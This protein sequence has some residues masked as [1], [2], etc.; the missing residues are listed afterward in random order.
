M[1]PDRVI[2]S[3]GIYCTWGPA[4][5]RLL[6]ENIPV[7]TYA[8]AKKKDTHKFNWTNSADWWDVSQEW[9]LVKDTPL[10]LEQE[11]SIDSYLQS[12]RNHSQDYRIYNFGEEE[13]INQ[14]L[15]HLKLDP[16]KPTFLLFTNVL[17]DAASTGR[18]MAFANPIDWVTQTIEWFLKHPEKQIIVKI[19]PAEK[20][21]GTNQPFTSI[22]A[23][24]FPEIPDNVKI[25]EPQDNVNSWSVMRVAQLGLVHTTTAGI[26]L[27]L[28]GTPCVVVSRT[29]YRGKGFTIDVDSRDEYF[30]IL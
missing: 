7:L 26:E 30:G 16:D 15:E 28:D 10:T 3:H 25:I 1:K 19:H 5:E 4:R 13:T 12:R 17:W 29:H 11:Y 9:E 20:V 2:M 23:Q 6:A 27:A 18:E 22:I 21:I 24:H 14:T 8:E